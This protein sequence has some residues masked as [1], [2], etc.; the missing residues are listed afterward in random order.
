[1]NG[2]EFDESLD[3]LLNLEEQVSDEKLYCKCVILNGR[4][5]HI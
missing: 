4:G 5:Q 3:I 1:M 2:T